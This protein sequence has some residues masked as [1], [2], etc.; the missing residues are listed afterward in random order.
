MERK[1]INDHK[2]PFR[3]TV[4]VTLAVAFSRV[5]LLSKKRFTLINLKTEIAITNND[6]IMNDIS[7]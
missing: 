6:K 2:I 5:I 1:P 4:L 3:I 7:N